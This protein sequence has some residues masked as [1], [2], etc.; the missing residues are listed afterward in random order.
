MPATG[1]LGV[2]EISQYALF[3]RLL[4]A[5]FVFWLA[6]AVSRNTYRSLGNRALRAFFLVVGVGFSMEFLA[7]FLQPVSSGLAGTASVLAAVSGVVDPLLLL[8]FS[9]AFPIP[10][11]QLRSKVL[12]TACASCAGIVL[13]LLLV[14]P[15][16]PGLPSWVSAVYVNGTYLAS[17]SILLRAY[18]RE[19]YRFR[20]R[21]LFFVTIGVG[22]AG[23]SRSAAFFT[24]LP[25]HVFPAP[26]TDVLVLGLA[27]SLLLTAILALACRALVGPAARRANPVF[28]WLVA[29]LVGFSAIYFLIHELD[30]ALGFNY[31]LD[32]QYFGFRWIGVGGILGY[33][34]LRYQL[35]DFEL[36][37]RQ[38]VLVLGAIMVG[39]LTA[40]ATA[41]AITD[42]VSLTSARATGLVAGAV[43]SLVV[44]A[45][46][47][48]L[49]RRAPQGVEL[50]RFRT[51]RIE[52]YEAALEYALAGAEWK[53]GE[54]LFADTLR[55]VF[56]ITQEEHR[57]I[58]ERLE[59]MSRPTLPP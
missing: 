41:L 8:L 42:S 57:L 47:G 10:H 50:P 32:A 11:P 53:L 49:W 44:Y 21:Q 55:E 22:F 39:L 3:A 46:L 37:T 27:A 38:A 56:D 18:L 25:M 54:H 20:G 35:F 30:A 40:F 12:W 43:C 26:T 51:R 45:I 28:G 59:K 2:A 23:L 24:D 19:R 36:R 33:G 48:W 31:T 52:I 1:P 5:V 13:L 29:C 58:V 16:P 34:I 9:L 14:A 6:W 7:W 15:P 17:F 4:P